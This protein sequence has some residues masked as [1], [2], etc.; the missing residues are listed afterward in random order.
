MTVARIALRWP[1]SSSTDV[2]GEHCTVF[3][4]ARKPFPGNDNQL[5]EMLHAVRVAAA[6]GEATEEQIAAAYH[7]WSSSSGDWSASLSDDLSEIAVQVGVPAP[8]T[9]R[10]LL[11]LLVTAGQVIA[12]TTSDEVTRYRRST[13]PPR[14]EEVLR[15]PTGQ[16]AM[17]RRQDAFHRYTSFAADLAA[18]AVWSPGCTVSATL[19]ELSRQLLAAEEEI[20]E[21]WRRSEEYRHAA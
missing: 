16:V 8:T 15:L 12:E 14:A 3:M 4:E 11:Q 19:G 18:V 10:E 9:R 20:C 6:P 5:T 1:D 13:K 7:P 17:I 21:A 2:P